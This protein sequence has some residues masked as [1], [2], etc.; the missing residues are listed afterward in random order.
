MIF[1]LS[2]YHSSI[3]IK[4]TWLK[5]TLLY[6]I[7]ISQISAQAVWASEGINLT[8][9]DTIFTTYYLDVLRI[10]MFSHEFLYDFII[11]C[12]QLSPGLKSS[13]FNVLLC[14]WFNIKDFTQLF[15][16]AIV[17]P[18]FW[19]YVGQGIT[20]WW[21]YWRHK[22]LGFLKYWIILEEF[23]QIWIWVIDSRRF[24]LS[25]LEKF[26]LNFWHWY[27]FNLNLIKN[28]IF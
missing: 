3:T 2:I 24:H 23:C 15:V 26:R 13:I 28:M 8:T 11:H 4:V 12:T 10:C 19:N 6:F 16:W 5:F 18:Y 25:P 21:L 7:I 14:Y 17:S 20:L 22:L 27:V 1:P 9:I